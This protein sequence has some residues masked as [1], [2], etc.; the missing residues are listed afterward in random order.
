MAYD[1]LM[2]YRVVKELQP[3]VGGR[4]NKVHQP[5]ALDLMIQV[6]SNRQSVSLLVSANAMY[7]R[8]QLTDTPIKNPQEPPMFCMMLR[9]HIEG[10][11]ITAI[12]QVGR[13]RVIVFSV[14]S[15]NE[16]GDEEN[17]RVY[18]ELMGRHS[19]V[20][21]TNEDGKILDA[22][23]HLPPSQ[24]TYRTIMPGS[25]Y[26]L[27][28][29]QQKSDPLTER[30]AGLKRIDWNAGMLDKQ[31]VAHFSGMSPQIA[32]EIMYRAKTPNRTNLE[33][34]FDSVM[35]DLDGA[36]VFQQLASGKERFSPIALTSGDI[37]S[38][39]RYDSSREVLD[40]FYY[41]K[42]NRD[43]V[44][45][46]AHDVER[47]LKSE[48]E[49]NQLK[50]KRLLEDM[51]ATER[52]DE[53]QKY[54]ELLTTYLFQLEKGMKVAH[55]VDYYDEDG[56]MIDIPLDP[57]KTPNE[58]AQR[59]YKK[60]NKLKVAKIEVQKQIELNETEIS[61]LETLVAQLDVAAP[62]DIVEIREELA[63]G[64]YI[65]QKRQKKKQTAKV[66][67]EGYTSSTGVEFYV[68]KNNTQNDYLTF[69]FARRDEVWL[70]VKDIPGSHVIIRST[71]PDETTLLEAATVA[72]Y[73][74][75]A[76][77]SSG[78]PVDYT[79]A[80]Y[81]KKPSGAKPGFVIYTDQQTVYV[82]PDEQLV[83]SLKQ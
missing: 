60:Y 54:G 51:K 74:S 15:R 12:E 23:K 53:L 44:K 41:E 11:F 9:K 46:Q 26:I 62:R 77:A 32:Q 81:V 42:A 55:V 16:L 21:L 4:I 33:A 20:V 57:L 7:A 47:L 3:L 19:N 65:R 13:D 10:G 2:T 30:E 28:P 31:L 27:P 68:G 58:N 73:F 52:S 29:A 6:R 14:R 45:Q 80:R 69:K 17:K 48:L 1:G 37:V 70:H 34:A 71:E 75:K 25:E 79:K 64:G 18:V 8:L 56:A 40:R 78:V 66:A 22:I 5:Y 24:N 43:R 50:R 61:Y 67:L 63:E 36:Y 83:K 39:E 38:E 59:Y 72:A 82:T 49:R 35:A 76:R